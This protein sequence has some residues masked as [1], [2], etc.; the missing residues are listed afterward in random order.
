MI[1]CEKG[2]HF[3]IFPGSMNDHDEERERESEGECGAAAVGP[4]SDSAFRSI[5]RV[6]DLAAD[7]SIGR[8]FQCCSPIYLPLGI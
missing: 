2:L 4:L 5:D 6:M 3:R 8:P 7:R 1:Q